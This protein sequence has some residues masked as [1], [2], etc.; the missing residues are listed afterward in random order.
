M[1]AFENSA[2]EFGSFICEP[3]SARQQR[4]NRAMKRRKNLRAET[5]FHISPAIFIDESP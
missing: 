5:D 4:Q 2:I 3:A 1:K